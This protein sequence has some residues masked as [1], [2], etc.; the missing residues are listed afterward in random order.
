M[1]AS[2]LNAS[3]RDVGATT[4]GLSIGVITVTGG[5]LDIQNTI[6]N[7]VASAISGNLTIVAVGDLEVTA[8]ENA[9]LEADAANVSLAIGLGLAIGVSLV[10]N[11]ILSD[12]SA[13]VA[14]T[15][16]SA[17]ASVTAANLSVLAESTADIEQTDTVGVAGALVGAV[18]NRADA[19]IKTQVTAKR[20]KRDCDCWW[21]SDGQR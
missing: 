20:C 5:G 9:Y 16:S 13:S 14:G 1:T 10:K 12:I 8:S 4:V 3:V 6:D 18:G 7:N 19:D 15:L 21:N 2:V 17:L 11:E